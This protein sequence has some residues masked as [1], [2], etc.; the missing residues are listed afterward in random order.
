MTRDG[1]SIL[2]EEKGWWT[3]LAPVVTASPKTPQAGR[4]V[5]QIDARLLAEKKSPNN[6]YILK[7]HWLGLEEFVEEEK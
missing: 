2:V 7:D 1:P 5:V 3:S 6:V 4:C